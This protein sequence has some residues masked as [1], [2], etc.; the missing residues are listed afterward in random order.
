[1]TENEIVE[2]CM[3]YLKSKK[4]S[5]S[6]KCCLLIPLKDNIDKLGRKRRRGIELSVELE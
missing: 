1:M 3:F 5:T 6:D 4:Y 2:A